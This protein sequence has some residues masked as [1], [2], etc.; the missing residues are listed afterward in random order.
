M[1]RN[2]PSRL[3]PLRVLGDL[4]MVTK[5]GQVVRWSWSKTSPIQKKVGVKKIPNLKGLLTSG[6]RLIFF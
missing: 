1:Q 4:Y 5:R 6:L 3:P 2:M